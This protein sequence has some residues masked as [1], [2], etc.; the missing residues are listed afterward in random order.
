MTET[1]ACASYSH[2]LAHSSIQSCGKKAFESTWRQ[3]PS[4]SKKCYGWTAGSIYLLQIEVTPFN[5]DLFHNLRKP[6][7]FSSQSVQFASNLTCT[8]PTLL[9]M[10]FGKCCLRPSKC[11]ISSFDWVDALNGEIKRSLA[12]S[13]QQSRTKYTCVNTEFQLLLVSVLHIGTTSK[14]N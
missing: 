1:D 14:I 11:F 13:S 5:L 4:I 6:T 8:R 7:S 12:L 10:V 2:F 3:H 9:T